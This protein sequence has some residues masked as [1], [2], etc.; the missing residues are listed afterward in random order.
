MT[1]HER[2]QT[3]IL[4]T[5]KR[6]PLT[7]T[8]AKGSYL[9]DQS[10][11]KY[12]DMYAGIAVSSLGHSN[13]AILKAIKKQMNKHLHLSNYFVSEPVVSLAQ[14]LVEHAFPSQVFFTNSGTEA[15]EASIKLVRKWGKSLD[16]EKQ[17]MIALHESFHGRTMGG[18]SLTGQPK[19]QQAFAPLLSG[20]KHIE[21][22]NI[23]QLRSAVSEKT[24]AIYLEL[25]QGESGIEPLHFEYIEEVMKLAKQY[26]FLIVADEIQTGLMRT[27][28]LF[29]YQHTKLTP[30]ILTLAKSLGGGIPL[31]AMLVA[32]NLSQVLQPGDHG[33]TFGGN[34]LACAMGLAS[35]N[36]L[37][38]TDMANKV[39]HTSAYLFEALESLKSKFDVIQDVRGKGLMIGID[40]GKHAQSIQEKALKRGVLLNVT[41]QTVIRLLPPLNIKNKDLLIFLKVFEDIIK[42]I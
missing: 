37:S 39:T 18:L 24:C 38:S 19:Y 40:L 13:K 41:H 6:L 30:D 25:I 15:I 31:G 7:I 1:L 16:S 29:A 5:Y 10:G 21:R 11:K 26:N 12:L 27:G 28:K 42:T 3:Y 34:P 32:N 35:F 17:D 20:V 36:L 2:D 23:N 4:N 14:K 22:N 8:K 33:S 9:Y